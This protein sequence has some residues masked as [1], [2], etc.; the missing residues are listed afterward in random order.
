MEMMWVLLGFFLF[1]TIIFGI[2]A[3]MFPEIVGI[4]GKKALEV[5]KHQQEDSKDV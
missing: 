3:Y 4:T 5:R 1:V 2:I